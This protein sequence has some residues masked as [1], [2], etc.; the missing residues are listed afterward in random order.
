M[1]ICGVCGNPT[2]KKRRLVYMLVGRRLN[3]VRA[4]GLCFADALHLVVAA[5]I[6]LTKGP[7]K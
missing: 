5:P 1:S 3:R 4:C 7:V 6:Q 2:R